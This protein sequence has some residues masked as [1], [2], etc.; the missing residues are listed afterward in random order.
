MAIWRLQLKSSVDPGITYLAPKAHVT[1]QMLF[2][3]AYSDEW[4]KAREESQ[5]CTSMFFW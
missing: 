3:A 5:G 4:G 1:E 2:L